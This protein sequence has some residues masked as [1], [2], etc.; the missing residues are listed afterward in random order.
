MAAY[1]WVYDSRHLQADCQDQPRNPT[2]SN[3]IRVTF[4]FYII[5]VDTLYLQAIRAMQSVSDSNDDNEQSTASTATTSTAPD[6]ASCSGA[7]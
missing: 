7:T 1:R 5:L 4:I 3:R 2:L 6:A